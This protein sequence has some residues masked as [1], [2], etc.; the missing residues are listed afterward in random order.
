MCVT[1]FI[2]H[3]GKRPTPLE[4]PLHNVYVTIIVLLS[5]PTESP[6]LVTV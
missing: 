2:G 5:A 4:R 6:P 3:P 1:H